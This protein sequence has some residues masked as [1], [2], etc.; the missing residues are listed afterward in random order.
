MVLKYST[1]GTP[2]SIETSSDS[3]WILNE[4]LEKLYHLNLIEFARISSWKLQIRMKLGKETY[5]CT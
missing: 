2:F 1:R 3:K 4:N 5:N